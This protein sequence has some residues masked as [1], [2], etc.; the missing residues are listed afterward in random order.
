[1][2]FIQTLRF[3]GAS[4]PRAS[5][6]SRRCQPCSLQRESFGNH[7]LVAGGGGCT[8]T[9]PGAVFEVEGVFAW[10]RSVRFRRGQACH[11]CRSPL[12]EHARGLAFVRRWGCP[13][14]A[15]TQAPP[16]PAPC[17]LRV[18]LSGLGPLECRA[19]TDRHWGPQR[20]KPA[21]LLP[22]ARP[23]FSCSGVSPPSPPPHWSGVV[24]LTGG[25]HLRVLEEKSGLARAALRPSGAARGRQGP[26]RGGGAVEGRSGSG[27]GIGT[28]VRR[29][30]RSRP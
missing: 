20:G 17:P 4:L 13:G 9:G 29:P 16:A 23:L 11:G 5:V 10:E 15:G 25:L 30:G 1:M 27:V 6:P 18:L 28:A 2:D 26:A 8:N 7:L 3:G 24:A 14:R 21:G 19:V 22:F 12:P